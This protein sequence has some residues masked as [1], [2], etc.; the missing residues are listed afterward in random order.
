MFDVYN[1]SLFS[2]L[3]NY[4]LKV[5]YTFGVRFIFSLKRRRDLGPK[6]FEDKGLPEWK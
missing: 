2:G 3:D 5:D 4:L 1:N 6:Y